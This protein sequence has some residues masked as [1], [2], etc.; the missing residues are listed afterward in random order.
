MNR[1]LSRCTREP[2]GACGQTSGAPTATH[3]P[4]LKRNSLLSESDRSE[5]SLQIRSSC[6]VQVLG[7]VFGAAAGNLVTALEAPRSQICPAR[8]L[9]RPPARSRARALARSPARLP[10]RQAAGPSARAPARS[11][12]RSPARSLARALARSPARPPARSLRSPGR[13]GARLG[14]SAGTMLYGFGLALHGSV[15]SENSVSFFKIL[16]A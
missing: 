3:T 14:N 16:N 7:A 13:P 2:S 9:A 1:G 12:A 6:F 8:S 4:N 11:L 5:F 15:R 10:A